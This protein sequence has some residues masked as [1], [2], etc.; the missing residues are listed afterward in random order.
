M[1]KPRQMSVSSRRHLKTSQVRTVLSQ[2]AEASR[3]WAGVKARPQTGPS[4]PARM[5]SSLPVRTDQTQTWNVSRQPAQMTCRQNCR[6]GMWCKVCCPWHLL[7]LQL[8]GP[9]RTAAPTRYAATQPAGQMSST[10]GPP[11]VSARNRD[12][13]GISVHPCRQHQHRH[14]PSRLIVPL[15]S[16]YPASRCGSGTGTSHDL[17][18]PPRWDPVPGTGIA[19]AWGSSWCGSCGSAQG[20]RR[21][22]CRPGRQ[23]RLRC[24]WARRPRLSRGQY[25]L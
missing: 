16:S 19:W 7:G 2:E 6:A 18:S 15:E 3:D 4:C 9:H 24:R 5:S 13:T 1:R 11:L 12:C 21:A 10:H 22:Q 14:P 8:P 20:R 23:T 25:V 17:S